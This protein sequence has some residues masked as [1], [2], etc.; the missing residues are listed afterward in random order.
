MTKKGIDPPT[1][2]S[3][4]DSVLTP[5]QAFTLWVLAVRSPFPI[6]FD[7]RRGTDLPLSSQPKNSRQEAAQAACAFF[8]PEACEKQHDCKFISAKGW[9]AAEESDNVDG[10]D[11]EE[12]NNEGDDDKASKTAS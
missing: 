11:G 4:G 2:Y 10:D 5:T 3:A 1:C 6:P 9:R 12:D 8:L 7:R